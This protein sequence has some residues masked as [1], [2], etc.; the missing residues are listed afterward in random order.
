MTLLVGE[1]P[2]LIFFR[3]DMYTVDPITGCWNWDGSIGGNGYGVARVGRS[4][5]SAHRFIYEQEVG[6][7]PPG[8]EPDHLCRNRGCVNPSHMELVTH[9]ENVLRAMQY[10][11]RVL[12]EQCK[13][14]HPLDG[15]RTRSGGGRYCKTCVRLSKQRQ[16]ANK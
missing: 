15:I 12:S 2:T 1:K 5:T 7:I 16:R 6:P 3:D 10:T 11:A 8:L 14:G 4:S 13:D 9:A